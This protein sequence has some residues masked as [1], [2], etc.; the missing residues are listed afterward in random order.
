MLLPACERPADNE[1]DCSA[2]SSHQTLRRLDIRTSEISHA[3][4][5]AARESYRDASQAYYGDKRHYGGFGQGASA[6]D[7][8]QNAPDTIRDNL[9]HLLPEDIAKSGPIAVTPAGSRYEIVYDF[10]KLL[11][12]IKKEV[13]SIK[14]LRP[15][16]N[17][18]DTA[19]Q[20]GLGTPR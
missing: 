4:L 15:F 2:A 12:K 20:R 6:A 10:T 13:F 11:A 8:S 7:I 1:V 16:E 3:P 17:I 14:G 18:R 19:G 9:N 5:R